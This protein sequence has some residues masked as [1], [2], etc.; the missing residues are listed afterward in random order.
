MLFVFF[1][2]S[3][4]YCQLN[5]LYGV[6]RNRVSVSYGLSSSRKDPINMS[7]SQSWRYGHC[8]Y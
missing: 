8:K 3:A 2:Y 6:S 1:V 4:T 7:K 5:M